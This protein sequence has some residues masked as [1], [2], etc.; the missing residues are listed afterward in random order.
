MQ[1]KEDVT[2]LQNPPHRPPRLRQAKISAQTSGST[3]INLQVN[4][5]GS[6]EIRDR[7]K[8]RVDLPTP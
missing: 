3:T 8:S 6:A 7:D 5:T 1:Q 4:A 2:L